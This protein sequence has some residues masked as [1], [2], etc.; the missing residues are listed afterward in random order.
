MRNT[1]YLYRRPNQGVSYIIIMMIALIL[2]ILIGAVST[3]MT[4]QARLLSRSAKDYLALA[5][6]EAG[7]NCILAEMKADYQFVTHG[8]PYIPLKGWESPRRHKQFNVSEVRGL[9]LDYNGSGVYSGRVVSPNARVVGEFKVRVRL[10]KALNSRDTK[11]IDE[12]HRYFLVEAIGCVDDTYRIIRGVIEKTIPG[13]YLLYDGQVLD[14][15]ALGPYPLFA[16][17]LNGG[18]LYGHELLRF[19]GRGLLDAGTD[20]EEVEKVSTPG[21]IEISKPPQ[22]RFR[23][24]VSGRVRSSTDAAFDT[25]AEKAG[26]TTIGEFVLD[27]TH[28][29]KSERLPALNPRYYK[30]ARDPAPEILD[31]NT[32]YDGFRESTWRNP[33]KPD[34]VVY[35]LH[36]GDE[37]K[38][39]DKKVLLYATVPLRIWGCPPAKATTLFCEKDVYICGDLNANPETPHN[40][41]LKWQDY[42][43]RLENGTDKN[44][45]AV[46]S[47]G[48]IWIDYSQPLLFL[49]DELRTWLDYQI[50]LR[51]GGNQLKPLALMPFVFPYRH[52]TSSDLRMPLT[53]LN[54]TAIAGLFSLPKEPPEAIPMMMAGLPMHGALKPLRRFMTPDGD[55]DPANDASGTP[56]MPPGGST[57]GGTGTGDGSG[58][59]ELDRMH[60]G[61]KSLFERGEVLAKIGAACYLTGVLTKGE[62]DSI[63]NS[64]L[65]RA[66]KELLEGEPDRRLGAWNVVNDM[67]ELAR[68]RPKTSFY[69]PE[70]TINAL[71]IDSGELNAKWDATGK[72][73]CEIGNIESKTARCF[74]YLGEK[75]Q[76]IIRHN[77]AMIHLR[78]TPATPFLDGKLANDKGVLRRTLWDNTYQRGGGEYYP[79]Y[80]PA[81]F[82]LCQWTDDSATVEDWAAFK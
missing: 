62:R 71:L 76:L 54:F 38:A 56:A 5:A 57:G 17:T 65:D 26:G 41:D 75:S 78:T 74:A 39:K 16:N 6:A 81:A 48:R 61:I 55:A 9:E 32:S 68:T 36:F 7:L 33:V 34:E 67:F 2:G 13:S 37:F 73:L 43:N 18:R 59:E 66:T 4:G 19:T 50:A 80:L 69:P 14:V 60:F 52:S 47:L 72:A 22:A 79:P 42:S 45:L 24:G 3:F 25:F 28:G 77:G 70:M 44:G 53:A 51:L 63:I 31:A 82:N 23:G 58:S 1:S 8:N 11:T 10:A 27:G 49:R 20:L 46:L 12:A 64:I 30:E 15:G 40:Y 29:G 35:D 21:H